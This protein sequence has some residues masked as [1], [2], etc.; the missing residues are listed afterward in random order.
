METSYD[1]VVCGGGTAGC[2]VANRL[3]EESE[4]TVLLLEAGPN[5]DTEPRI[6][7]P[8]QVP[9]LRKSKIDWNFKVS[10]AFCATL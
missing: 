8:S 4:D 1:Y 7:I 3:T 10:Y 2:I 5:D 9:Y 6:K